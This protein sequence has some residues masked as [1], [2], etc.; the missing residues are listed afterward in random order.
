M[1]NYVEGALSDKTN[2]VLETPFQFKG[3]IK[4]LEQIRK[5]GYHMSMYQLFVKDA[6]QSASRMEARFKTGGLF[7]DQEDVEVNF[8]A[9]LKNVAISYDR[10]D[11]ST[12][13]D[14]SSS[15][16][17]KCIAEFRKKQLTLF[18]PCN[19]SYL[20]KLFGYSATKIKTTAKA[21]R[22]ILANKIYPA[23]LPKKQTYKKKLK[24]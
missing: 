21:Y 13:I 16:K 3:T 5:A 7:I 2:F 4:L 23:L 22:I 15:N 17:L 6:G 10:F 24:L 19:H 20:K 12:F 11:E 9:N 1:K 8:N 14:N 18:N